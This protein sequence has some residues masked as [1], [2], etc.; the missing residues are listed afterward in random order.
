MARLIFHVVKSL[1]DRTIRVALNASDRMIHAGLH[2]H[3]TIETGFHTSHQISFVIRM[4]RCSMLRVS[5][6]IV[7]DNSKRRSRDCVKR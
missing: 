6:I 3:P 5:L 2:L 7:P 4:R 1:N